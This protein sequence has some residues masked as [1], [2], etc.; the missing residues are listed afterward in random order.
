MGVCTCPDK[1]NKESVLAIQRG[2]FT[3]CLDG[4]MPRVSD[5]MTRSCAAVQMLHG[6]GSHWNS[7]NRWFDKTLQVTYTTTHIYYSHIYTFCC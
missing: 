3:L 4:A 5:E 6:G 2:I 7:G 1:T